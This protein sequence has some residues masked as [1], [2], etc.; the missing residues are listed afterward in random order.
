MVNQTL[1]LK[2]EVFVWLI[3]I[4]ILLATPLWA[5]IGIV[6][7]FAFVIGVP[8]LLLGFLIYSGYQFVRERSA[9][10]NVLDLSE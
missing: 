5:L 6:L 3:T 10:D 1:T 8:L 2:D 7:Q 4:A 9:V